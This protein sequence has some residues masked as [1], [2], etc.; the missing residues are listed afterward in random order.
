M[1]VIIALSGCGKGALQ[2]PGQ[3]RVQKSDIIGGALSKKNESMEVVALIEKEGGFY[4]TGTLIAPK[5][6]LTAAHCVKSLIASDI[7]VYAGQG[8]A[9]RQME[10]QVEAEATF[11]QDDYEINSRDDSDLGL[12]VLKDTLKDE[13]GKDIVPAKILTQYSWLQDLREKKIV[14]TTL[15]GFGR[16]DP[17][18]KLKTGGEKAAVEVPVIDVLRKEII[19]GSRE[20]LKGSCKGDSGG[21]A[22]VA[23]KGQ[24][25][26]IGV[27]SRAADKEAC[28]GGTSYYG[29]APAHVCWMEKVS[30]LDLGGAGLGCRAT[31]VGKDEVRPTFLSACAS[32]ESTAS[33]QTAAGLARAVGGQSCQESYELLQNATSLNLTN[34]DLHDFSVLADFPNLQTINIEGN[35]I[36]DVAVLKNHPGLKDIYVDGMDLPVGG[37]LSLAFQ[38]KINIHFKGSLLMDFLIQNKVSFLK[39]FL[40]RGMDPN[41][42]DQD[43]HSAFLASVAME[44][45]DLFDLMLGYGGDVDV[46]D[47][48]GENL[49]FFAQNLDIYK[50]ILS[51]SKNAK[52]L[53]GQQSAIGMTPLL[54]A[55]SF[56][57]LDFVKYLVEEMGVDPN[58]NPG[59]F[60]VS[61]IYFA[62]MNSDFDIY[63]YLRSKVP[64]EVQIDQ[65]VGD[66][67]ALD[68]LEGADPLYSLLSFARSNKK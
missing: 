68:D 36:V 35:P 2:G 65:T 54:R 55:V 42:K 53:L 44:R 12:I 22:F 41:W 14:T 51:L 45:E 67:P 63:H 10:G 29:L 26:L 15:V 8:R 27:T 9:D 17:N 57:N 23:I 19:V 58:P 20:P 18:L 30:G 3:L 46:V 31:L 13:Q 59:N 61:P 39:M 48:H 40:A 4:C 37:I 56:S 52:A 33:G 66:G 21:P 11:V 43:G 62:L 47:A 60:F 28:Y 38:K 34:R 24:R 50:K 5:L 49:L 25:Y 1:S 16:T 6:V 64:E 32:G 7:S